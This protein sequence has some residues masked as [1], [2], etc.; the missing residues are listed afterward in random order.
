M[1]SNS[2]A[3]EFMPLEG[4]ISHRIHKFDFKKEFNCPK[5]LRNAG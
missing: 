2:R 3:I 4:S 1:Y 5:N